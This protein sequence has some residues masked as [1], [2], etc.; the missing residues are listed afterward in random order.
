MSESNMAAKRAK[1]EGVLKVLDAAGSHSYNKCLKIAKETFH[2]L[3][4]TNISQ[5]LH[6][7]PRDHVTSSGA[8]FWSGEKRPPTPITFDANDPLQRRTQLCRANGVQPCV[9]E[10]GVRVQTGRCA[11][12]LLRNLHDVVELQHGQRLRT[13]AQGPA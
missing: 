8:L 6:N 12:Q 13:R 3:F 2:E 1:V 11:N 5:L 4:Y 10:R 9:H 7:F